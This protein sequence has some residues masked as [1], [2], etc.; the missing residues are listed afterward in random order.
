MRLSD[1]EEWKALQAIQPYLY[2][3]AQ[4]GETGI[5]ESP[6]HVATLYKFLQHELQQLVISVQPDR[7]VDHEI[8]HRIKKEAIDLFEKVHPILQRILSNEPPSASLQYV[9]KLLGL[10][11]LGNS[12]EQTEADS[13]LPGRMS[14]SDAQSIVPALTSFNERLESIL[15]THLHDVTPV[16]ENLELS[17]ET[18]YE[19]KRKL[20]DAFIM[21]LERHM[22]CCKRRSEHHML[23]Q[24]AG[25][26]WRAEDKS[27]I[28]LLLSSCGDL[29]GWQEIECLSDGYVKPSLKRFIQN[30]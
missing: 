4:H 28:S 20:I 21:S 29:T 2:K 10:Q 14:L 24:G 11:V 9:Q 12:K 1:L 30:H 23:L 15:K 17:S 22:A 7:D 16:A 25:Q 6:P 5:S 13:T 19:N 3:A 27:L 26:S 8:I 18:L